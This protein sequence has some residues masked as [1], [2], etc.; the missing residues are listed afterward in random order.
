MSAGI[1]SEVE[2]GRANPAF[3]TLYRISHAL[4]LRIGDL[5]EDQPDVPAANATVIHKSQRKRLQLGDHGLVWE[6]LTPNLQ[7]QLE[8]LLTRVPPGFSNRDD[9]FQHRG[10]ECVVLLEGSL[11]VMVGDQKFELG[12]G[13]AITYDSGQNHWWHNPTEVEG[14]IVGAVTPPSF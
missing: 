6:L 7:G 12:R 10:E 2:R 3:R 8:M 9:P 4:D 5:F 13:D 14:L 11:E 1:I